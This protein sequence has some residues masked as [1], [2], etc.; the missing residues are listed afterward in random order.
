MMQLKEIVVGKNR[1]TVDYFKLAVLWN[2]CESRPVIRVLEEDEDGNETLNDPEILQMIRDAVPG[3]N[4]YLMDL[5]IRTNV[6]EATLD[7]T[8]LTLDQKVERVAES[9]KRFMA[10]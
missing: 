5:A 6:H 2:L 10:A 8:D 4:S 1:R 7:A 9:I 3:Q